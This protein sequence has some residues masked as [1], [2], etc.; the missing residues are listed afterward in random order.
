MQLGVTKV[1]APIICLVLDKANLVLIKHILWK[2]F[3]HVIISFFCTYLT[4]NYLNGLENRLENNVRENS[5]GIFYFFWKNSCLPKSVWKFCRSDTTE[6]KTIS[7]TDATIVW[8]QS[9]LLTKFLP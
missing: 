5:F 8:Y 1:Y 9:C 6:K 4:V 7:G 3:A 2:N